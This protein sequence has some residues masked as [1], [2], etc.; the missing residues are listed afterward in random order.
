LVLAKYSFKT[1]YAHNLLSGGYDLTDKTGL[2]YPG[3]HCFNNK[4]AASSKAR[5]MFVPIREIMEKS[6]WS[7]TSTFSKFYNK[8]IKGK[9]AITFEDA[10]LQTK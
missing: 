10:V 5:K 2:L 7:N 1:V 8:P 4:S 9:R 6:G 3:R